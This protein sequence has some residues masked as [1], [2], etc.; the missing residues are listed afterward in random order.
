MTDAEQ[1]PAT[2]LRIGRVNA[3]LRVGDIVTWTA[4]RSR[5]SIWIERLTTFRWNVPR[6]V[7]HTSAIASIVDS[8]G[9]NITED[10]TSNG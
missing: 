7:E 2:N 4:Q 8:N 6:F 1:K 10:H 5:R 3:R 9:A